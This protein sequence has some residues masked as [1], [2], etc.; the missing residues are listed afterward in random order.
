MGWSCNAN[1][2]PTRVYCISHTNFL[3]WENAVIWNKSSPKDFG[4]GIVDF[5]MELTIYTYKNSSYKYAI[6]D[7]LKM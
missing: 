7:F 3:Y 5:N 6:T 4:K 1:W 2:D